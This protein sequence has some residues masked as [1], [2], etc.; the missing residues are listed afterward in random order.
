MLGSIPSFQHGSIAGAFS[1][2]SEASRHSVGVRKAVKVGGI[3]WI[4]C[5]ERWGS[6]AYEILQKVKKAVHPKRVKQ[7]EA[8]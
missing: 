1:A 5:G 3:L 2:E 7:A 8:G 4:H 6:A